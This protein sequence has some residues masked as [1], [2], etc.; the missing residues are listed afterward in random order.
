MFTIPCPKSGTWAPGCPSHG[1]SL[2]HLKW[3][4]RN[5]DHACWIAL[6]TKKSVNTCTAD[7]GV[8]AR[9]DHYFGDGQSIWIGRDAHRRLKW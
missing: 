6:L 1:T 9:A 7:L 8:S 4:L 2:C 5:G 3:Y